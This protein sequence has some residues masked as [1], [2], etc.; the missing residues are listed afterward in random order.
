MM[1]IESGT[2]AITGET[3][4]E[5]TNNRAVKIAWRMDRDRH[6]SPSLLA[7][8]KKGGWGDLSALVKPFR[9]LH[10]FLGILYKLCQYQSK[11]PATF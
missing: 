4:I 2:L 11:A 3:A 7:P 10:C 8:L 1:E 6:Q 9:N 5:R